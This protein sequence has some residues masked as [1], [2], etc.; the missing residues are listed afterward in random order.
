VEGAQ[1]R[2]K[3]SAS[4]KARLSDPAIAQPESGTSMVAGLTKA[5]EKTFIRLEKTFIRLKEGYNMKNLIFAPILV[6]LLTLGCA[7]KEYVKVKTG[8]V[9]DR[10]SQVE[11]QSNA[12]YAALSSQEQTD[13]SR[14]DERITTT[15]NKIAAVSSTADQASASAAQALQQAQANKAQIDA[16]AADMVKIQDQYM[17]SLDYTLVETAN[18]TF[19]FNRSDLSGPAKATL[20][21]VIQKL[22]TTPR[23]F[24]EVVGFTDTIGTEK[25]NLTLS[26]QRADSVARY[27]VRGNVDLSRI[28]MI[29]MGEEQTPTQLAAEVEGFSGTL[30][31]KEQHALARRARIRVYVPG[32][33]PASAEAAP[34]TGADAVTA[35]ND[36]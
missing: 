30:S 32:Q 34:A 28:N 10:V 1:N 12:Q 15:D 24:V 9:N 14:L 27:L 22:T 17:K 6:S 35:A 4:Y 20:D 21:A 33:V 7:T 29:G 2:L 19:G 13:V 11:A 8:I 26:R 18:V 16:N 23:S 25:Y 31:R 36:R 5:M 3:T